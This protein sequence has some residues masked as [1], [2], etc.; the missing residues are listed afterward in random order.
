[1]SQ[2]PLWDLDFYIDRVSQIPVLS[3]EDE[4]A[5]ATRFR[6]EP[7]WMP[8]GSWAVAPAIRGAHR[9]WI[10]RVRLP[11][12]IWS[13]RQRGSHESGSSVSTLPLVRLVSFAVALDPG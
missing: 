11:M 2:G 1:V 13:R 5:L 4:I 10:L 9:P 8:P 12:G 7:I 3:K 6:S